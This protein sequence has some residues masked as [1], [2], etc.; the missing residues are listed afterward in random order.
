MGLCPLTWDC[1]VQILS[2]EILRKAVNHTKVQENRLNAGIHR[3][4][5]RTR[6]HGI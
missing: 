3:R 5:A 4:T 6:H 1:L 2:E